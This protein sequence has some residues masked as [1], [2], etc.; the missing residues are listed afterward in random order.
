MRVTM[1]KSD[2]APHGI[3]GQSAPRSV[4]K[5]RHTSST[6]LSTREERGEF[7]IEGS[8]GDYRVRDDSLL[9]DSFA[10]NMFVDRSAASVVS[11]TST[12]KQPAS[13]V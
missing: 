1:L 8:I 10:F 6:S 5:R 12:D 3:L 11:T 9:G 13:L 4:N 2:A 7:E